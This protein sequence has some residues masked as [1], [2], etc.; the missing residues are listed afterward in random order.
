MCLSNIVID[1][2]NLK[3]VTGILELALANDVEHGGMLVGH[4][5]REAVSK[6]I[7]QMPSVVARKDSKVVGFLLEPGQGH[8][9]RYR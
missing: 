2:A 3:D 4:L 7:S 6:T 5:E 8:Q 1:R 9:Y